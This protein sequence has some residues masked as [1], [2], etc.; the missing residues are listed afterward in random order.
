M[1][2]VKN[3]SKLFVTGALLWCA[4]AQG[5]IRALI[6]DGQNNHD[7]KATTPILKS[8]LEETRL[9][10]VDVATSPPHGSDLSG[11]KPEFAK[12]QVVISNYNGDPWPAATLDALA[13]YVRAGGGFVSYHAADNAFPESHE[14]NEMIG[15]GGWGDRDEKSGPLVRFH[16]GKMVRVDQPGKA[17]HHGARLPFVV[18]VRDP[19][20][21][22]MRGLPKQWMHAADELYDS[23]RGPADHLTLLATAFSDP[24]NK[25]TGEDEPMLFT[26]SYGKGR[27]FH[28]TLGHD[29]AAM[30]C[31]GFIATFDRGAEWAATGK[32]TQKAPADFPGAAEVRTRP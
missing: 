25:G 16:D 27:V 8:L 1:N 3:C 17:G 14:Y 4:S 6:V 26:I 7:W 13:E 19:S 2:L 5:Q 24:A 12:Y 30:K 31:V 32:V 11:F 29:P 21:P 20:H 23:L 10:T 18:T 28:T 9:F 22:V 15:V